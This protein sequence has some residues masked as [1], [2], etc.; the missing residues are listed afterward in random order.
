MQFEAMCS[1]QLPMRV[2]IR[3]SAADVPWATDTHH[4]HKNRAV[5]LG[6]DKQSST[7]LYTDAT[8]LF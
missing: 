2:V 3:S 7:G 4:A 5:I 8:G 6:C 1:R